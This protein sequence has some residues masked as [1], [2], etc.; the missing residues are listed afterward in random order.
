MLALSKV[1]NEIE[2]SRQ[3]CCR[4]N[5]WACLI[6]FC[7]SVNF[8]LYLLL[9][10]FRTNSRTNRANGRVNATPKCCSSA[11]DAMK[12]WLPQLLEPVRREAAVT[13]DRGQNDPIKEM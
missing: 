1:L 5:K 6:F 9:P 3:K 12:L 8:Q 10:C 13:W 2:N 11:H 7:F 4:N